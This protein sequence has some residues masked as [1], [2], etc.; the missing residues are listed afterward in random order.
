MDGSPVGDVLS[1]TLECIYCPEQLCVVR[2]PICKHF[3]LFSLRGLSLGS[4]KSRLAV[5]ALAAKP[6]SQDVPKL[7]SPAHFGVAEDWNLPMWDLH[8]G[9]YGQRVDLG[10]QIVIKSQN[11]TVA[12]ALAKTMCMA[13]IV[14][15]VPTPC[16]II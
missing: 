2:D 16:G 14:V 6:S 13:L 12:M 8:F 10:K 3:L 1:R 5:S 7:V 11:E 9:K 15:N 4:S